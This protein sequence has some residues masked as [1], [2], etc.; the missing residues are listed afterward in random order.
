MRAAASSSSSSYQS[1][2]ESGERPLVLARVRPLYFHRARWLLECTRPSGDI[3]CI[4]L[5]PNLFG[6]LGSSREGS[7]LLLLLS[8][9][10]IANLVACNIDF[11]RCLR[12][13][14]TLR[15]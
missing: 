8:V 13:H 4:I 6:L 11:L 7:R 15:Q 2:E 9:R 3:V 5:R 1:S 14:L 12:F 10:E